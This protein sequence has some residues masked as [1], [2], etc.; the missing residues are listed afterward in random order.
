VLAVPIPDPFAGQGIN[1]RNCHLVDDVKDTPGGGNRSYADFARR[2][3]V[4]ARDDGRTVTPRNS[5]SLSRRS[6]HS[7]AR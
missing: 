7:C 4:P 3:P 5:P 2:S 1:C 6:P